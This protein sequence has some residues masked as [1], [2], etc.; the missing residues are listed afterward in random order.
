MPT[1]SLIGAPGATASTPRG[2][3][4]RSR[5]THQA[6]LAWYGSTGR[7]GGCRDDGAA[8]C[9]TRVAGHL[10]DHVDLPL[11]VGAERGHRHLEHAV[12]P[13]RRPNP[14]GVEIAGHLV[15]VKSCRARRSPG[16]HAPA[17]RRAPARPP[18]VEHHR[19][20]E[21]RPARG[22]GQELHE[23]RAARSIPSGS[24]PAR[25]APTPPTQLS[26][27][28]V[29]ATAMGVK[30]AASSRTRRVAPEISLEARP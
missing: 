15:A 18:H 5:C 1:R 23:R 26:R 3:R 2:R 7:P 19:P 17:P 16:R 6:T 10:F 8:G 11:G 27:L 22:E 9:R 14:M 25:S 4:G 13:V 28:D 21:A 29:R 12:A 30:Y 24:Q 20:A